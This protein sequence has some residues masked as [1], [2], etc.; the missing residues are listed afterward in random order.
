MFSSSVLQSFGD[1][2]LLVVGTMLGQINPAKGTLVAHSFLDKTSIFAPRGRVQLDSDPAAA[3][4]RSRS[5]GPSARSTSSIGGRSPGT[6]FLSPSPSRRRAECSGGAA[7]G[8]LV[9]VSVIPVKEADVC[10][11]RHRIDLCNVVRADELFE[12]TEWFAT[13]GTYVAARA[14]GMLPRDEGKE[15]AEDAAWHAGYAANLARVV[16]KLNRQVKADMR[17]GKYEA[18]VL[19]TQSLGRVMRAVL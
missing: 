19:E 6:S 5:F 12:D 8:D 13:K 2:S 15:M 3:S 9:D 17:N 1:V 10:G 14:A 16:L 18:N 7:R 11:L 4:G